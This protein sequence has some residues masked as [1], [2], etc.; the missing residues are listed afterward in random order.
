MSVKKTAKSIY[1]EIEDVVFIPKKRSRKKKFL[2][3]LALILLFGSLGTWFLFSRGYLSDFNTPLDNL[4]LFNGKTREDSANNQEQNLLIDR[5][6]PKQDD[7]AGSSD[8]D[9]KTIKTFSKKACGIQ[10]GGQETY[11]DWFTISGEV[12]RLKVSSVEVIDGELSNTRIWYTTSPD[13]ILEGGTYIEVGDGAPNYDTGAKQGSYVISNWSETYRLR[14]LCWNSDYTIEV[15][16][17][18]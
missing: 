1:Q 13:P 5:Y 9:F 6:Q 8:Y 10:A 11:T 12:W 18:K 7:E 15:Q 2:I 16:D 14:I 3:I 17:S 4:G